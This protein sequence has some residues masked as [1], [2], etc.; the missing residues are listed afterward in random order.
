M[1]K[2]FEENLDLKLNFCWFDYV[3]YDMDIVN[4]L[5][6]MNFKKN[7]DKKAE[8]LG[9][10][11]GQRKNLKEE[12]EKKAFKESLLYISNILKIENLEVEK[13]GTLHLEVEYE[14]QPEPLTVKKEISSRSSALLVNFRDISFYDFSSK[15]NKGIG[16]FGNGDIE[17]NGDEDE[18]KLIMSLGKEE[19]KDSMMVEPLTVKA[20]DE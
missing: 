19:D 18:D 11:T 4:L 6:G 8:F 2:F 7:E 15:K 5:I 9:K 16:E 14:G 10:K 1:Q 13:G 12:F 3:D 20:G 17:E